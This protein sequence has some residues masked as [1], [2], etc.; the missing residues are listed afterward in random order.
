MN[1]KETQPTWTRMTGTQLKYTLKEMLNFVLEIYLYISNG[2][3]EI[4]YFIRNEIYLVSDRFKSPFC[5]ALTTALNHDV[6]SIFVLL[7][8]KCHEQF[9]LFYLLLK[10][11]HPYLKTKS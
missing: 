3:R 7:E 5:A 9:Y 11:T 8:T 4:K 10:N 2:R 1:T 6:Y